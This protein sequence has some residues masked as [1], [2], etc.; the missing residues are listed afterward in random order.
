VEQRR[1]ITPDGRYVQKTIS[2]S[3]SKKEFIERVRLFSVDELEMMLEEAGFN[4]RAKRG[5]YVGGPIT[6]ESPRAIF[7]AV[8]E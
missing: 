3:G 5:D 2:L 6:D 4:V 1:I 8:R 7:F